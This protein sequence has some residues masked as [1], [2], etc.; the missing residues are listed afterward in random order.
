MY[1]LIGF[2]LSG[3][4]IHEE[5]LVFSTNLSVNDQYKYI[6]D[7][8]HKW[9]DIEEFK[10]KGGGDCEDFALAKYRIL[11]RE[12]DVPKDRLDFIIVNNN[13]VIL[14]YIGD[15]R[16]YYLDLDDTVKLKSS[17]SDF[18]VLHYKE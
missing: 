9:S 3:C 11:T 8:V 14:R 4:S 17:W 7:E 16:T 1:L 6:P 10:A 15:Y 13:H 12:L 18:K 5:H 2:L